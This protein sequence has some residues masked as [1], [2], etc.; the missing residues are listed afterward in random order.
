M[1]TVHGMSVLLLA[2]VIVLH[3]ACENAEGDP[4]TGDGDMDG[5]D[6]GDG[7]VDGDAADIPPERDYIADGVID[8]APPVLPYV[9]LHPD[10]PYAVFCN[11]RY[12]ITWSNLGGTPPLE[13]M[14]AHGFNHYDI[15]FAWQDM[16]SPAIDGEPMLV[17]DTFPEDGN[18]AFNDAFFD[19]L[20]Q[21]LVDSKELGICATLTLFGGPV[22]EPGEGRWDANPWN[23]AN[24][25]PIASSES[26]MLG[27]I[28]L[29]DHDFN[30]PLTGRFDAYDAEWPEPRKVQYRIEEIL[31]KLFLELWGLDNWLVNVMWEISDQGH[32]DYLE[33]KNWAAWLGGYIHRESPDVLVFTGEGGPSSV[34]KAELGSF[35]YADICNNIDGSMH[36]ALTGWTDHYQA[37]EDIG[38]NLNDKPKIMVGDDPLDIANEPCDRCETADWGAQHNIDYLK[39]Q[40]LAGL[41]PSTPFHFTQHY[42]GAAQQDIMD[43]VLELSQLL[44]TVET[45]GNE[46][47]DEITASALP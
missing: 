7:A 3:A 16:L 47:G 19:N 24:G 11:D 23:A 28:T 31:N 20:R 38:G 9:H 13:T 14:A 46:P 18:I 41:H 40:L 17:D 34:L 43:Y 5:G 42:E 21:R 1:R 44:E 37:V 6:I 35:F 33:A 2:A 32:G 10:N 12:L 26:G 45:W 39:A 29:E 25:G 27:L 22:F 8:E 36:E 4:D 30:D 15:A